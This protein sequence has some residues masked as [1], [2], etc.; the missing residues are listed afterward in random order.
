MITPPATVLAEEF[1]ISGLTKAVSNTNFST[2]SQLSTA[3][4]G[5]H[6]VSDGSQNA[7]VVFAVPI[8][9]RGGTWTLAL[10]TGTFA[11]AGIATIAG[12]ADAVTFTDITTIDC[13][14]ASTV[15]AVRSEA[16]GVT[17]PEGT[18]YIRVKAA[19][20]NASSTNYQ[21]RVGALYGVRTGA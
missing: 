11:T 7:E 18:K 21:I 14:S 9:L 2:F 1:E 17:V 5:G 20:K 10:V 19:T 12:S 8:P 4:L 15:A 13:Y 3:F 16:V 6:R